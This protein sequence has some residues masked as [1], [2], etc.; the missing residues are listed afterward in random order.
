[1]PSPPAMQGET[2]GVA[3]VA[4]L[5]VAGILLGLMHRLLAAGDEG[6]Q[7][8][9]LALGVGGALWRVGLLGW[10]RLRLLKG[11]RVAR[12]I[13]LRLAR[14]VR[15][16]ANDAHR[17][18]PVFVTLIKALVAPPLHVVLGTSELRIVL[19]ILLLRRC[20]HAVIVLGV[21]IIIF[22]C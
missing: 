15:R 17:G 16:I 2:V 18:L 6:W 8:V 19:P 14:A 20:D 5:S 11:L 13:W 9:D 22:G 3:V 12:D 1:M 10:W 21:L 7:T 4:V